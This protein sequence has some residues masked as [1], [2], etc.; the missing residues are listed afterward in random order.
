MHTGFGLGSKPR[1][2]FSISLKLLPAILDTRPRE[3][4]LVIKTELFGREKFK[5][6]PLDEGSLATLVVACLQ[7]DVPVYAVAVNGTKRKAK[8]GTFLSQDEK[9]WL[10]DR[11]NRHLDREEGQR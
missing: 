2:A 6:F 9:D 7:N 3:G 4:V 8:F 1:T 11:I 5:E 10:V